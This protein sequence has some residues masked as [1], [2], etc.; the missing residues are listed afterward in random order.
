MTYDQSEFDV[1]CEWGGQGI[2]QLAPI[3]DVIIIVDVFS[4]ATSVEIATHR[5]AFIVPY[6]SHDESAVALAASLGATLAAPIR[7]KT[8]LT[9]S[10]QSLVNIAS[11]TRLI[12]PSRNGSALTLMTGRKRTL[13]GCFRNYAAVG[14]AAQQFG[15]RIG[16]V[17]AGERWKD[18]GTLRPALEDWLGAGAIIS[19]LAGSRSPEASAAVAAFEEAREGLGSRLKQCSS[20]KELIENGFEQDVVLASEGNISDCVPVY[21]DGAFSRLDERHSLARRETN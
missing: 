2:V 17:P 20:G 1:R 21:S 10:P 16:V 4:F 14:A 9:L 18:D 8:A 15:R 12:L 6:H 13:A 19:Q 5:G 11:G 3:S 7:S